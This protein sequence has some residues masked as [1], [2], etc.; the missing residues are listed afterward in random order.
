[1]H[2]FLV[3]AGLAL[4]AGCATNTPQPAQQPA[5][6]T[7]QPKANVVDGT[8]RYAYDCGNPGNGNIVNIFDD[9]SAN[10]IVQS[11]GAQ[12]QAITSYSYYGKNQPETFRV[13]IM[14]NKGQEPMELEG[15]EDPRYE[16]H[17]LP[18]GEARPATYVLA[19]NKSYGDWLFMCQ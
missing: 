13:A 19:R 15:S 10:V 1:M 2:K 11:E 8:G 18:D 4:L 7:T 16:L 3:I 5:V 9:G 17:Y 12:Y 6:P 14:F